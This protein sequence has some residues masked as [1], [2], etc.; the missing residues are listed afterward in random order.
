MNLCEFKSQPGLHSEFHA[1]QG[2]T[3]K[4]CLGK[5]KFPSVG[6]IAW[7]VKA[8][9]CKQEDLNLNPQHPHESHAGLKFQC[10]GRQVGPWSPLA[11]Q[12]IKIKIQ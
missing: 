6:E 11:R 12:P 9:P 3:V 5:K 4:L 1:S 2:Y 10:P 8:R 7:L